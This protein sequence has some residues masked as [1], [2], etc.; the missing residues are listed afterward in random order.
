[1][2]LDVLQNILAASKLQKDEKLSVL[3]VASTKLNFLRGLELSLIPEF[4]SAAGY[5]PSTQGKSK[6]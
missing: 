1:L 4:Y 5:T 3:E 6:Q 2:I